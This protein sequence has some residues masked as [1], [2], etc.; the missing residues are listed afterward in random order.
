MKTLGNVFLVW[1][2]LCCLTIIGIIWGFMFIGLG[3]LLRIA[4]ALSKRTAG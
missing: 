2:V 1:G 3:A 4:A